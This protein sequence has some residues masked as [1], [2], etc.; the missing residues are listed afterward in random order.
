MNLNYQMKIMEFDGQRDLSLHKLKLH[1][2][3][4]FSKSCFSNSLV[5]K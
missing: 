4:G 3:E 1:S 2:F 5:E